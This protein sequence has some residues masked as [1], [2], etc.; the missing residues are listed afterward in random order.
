[1]REL[2][3]RLGVRAPSLYLYVESRE[4][5]LLRLI[6]SGVA[7]LGAGQAAAFGAALPIRQRFHEGG[8]AYTSFANENPHLFPLI[9]GPC[10]D[11]R[12]MDP[13]DAAAA[14]RPLLDAIAEIVAPGDVLDVSQAFWS[15]VHGYATL[16]LNGQFVMGG[17]PEA[18]LHRAIDLLLDALLAD[19][20]VTRR[21]PVAI[22]PA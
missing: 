1:M 2:A 14:S 10:P 21:A 17:N 3:R 9:F 22:L 13:D 7:K 6:E 18:A 12:R 4:D 20:A 8:R 19:A 5:L 11:E 15:L 16:A